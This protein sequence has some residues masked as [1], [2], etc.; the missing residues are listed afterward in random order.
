MLLAAGCTSTEVIES[1]RDN[2]VKI[3]GT[4][5]VIERMYYSAETI[6]Y[7]DQYDEELP[8]SVISSEPGVTVRVRVLEAT[9]SG[10]SED[11]AVSAVVTATIPT[12]LLGRETD[13]ASR[14]SRPDAQSAYHAFYLSRSGASGRL[15]CRILS[16]VTDRDDNNAYAGT[17]KITGGTQEGEYLFEWRL[18][19]P[20]GET[21]VSEG[22]V[23][24]AFER[25]Q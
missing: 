21:A 18:T 10:G 16:W 9:G 14:N 25:I 5:Y 13:L 24:G 23:T 20:S 1:P 12:R 11:G 4:E 17:F 6:E 19:D 2:S 15:Y 8:M 7:P 22:Y 3:N